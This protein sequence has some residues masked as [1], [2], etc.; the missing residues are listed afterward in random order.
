LICYI[1]QA[2]T[3]PAA[4]QW[5]SFS[6]VVAGGNPVFDDATSPNFPVR[7]YRAQVAW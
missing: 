3:N 7:F 2:T 5:L 6:N 4:P 1:I